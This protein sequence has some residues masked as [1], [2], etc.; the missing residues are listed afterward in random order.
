MSLQ[1]TRRRLPCSI[2]I[3]LLICYFLL[4]SLPAWRVV[5]SIESKTEGS[6][7][8]L[9]MAKAYRETIE[10]ELKEICNQ[11]LVGHSYVYKEYFSHT[12]NIFM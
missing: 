11:V 3:S 5:S 10:D 12:M 1:I 4:S 8:K 9:H 6:E 2:L 7:K